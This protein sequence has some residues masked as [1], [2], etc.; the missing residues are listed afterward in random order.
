MV[1]CFGTGF[2]DEVS[3]ARD[4]LLVHFPACVPYLL[5]DKL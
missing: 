3:W 5:F 1:V 4:R 2:G